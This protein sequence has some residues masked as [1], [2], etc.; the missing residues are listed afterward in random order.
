MRY[1]K[2]ADETCCGDAEASH[3]EGRSLFDSI[4]SES[5]DQGHGHGEDVDGDRHEL[6]VCGRVAKLL[7]HRWHSGRE[8]ENVSLRRT[9]GRASAH[10]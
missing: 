1:R 8:A 10:P 6:G 7:D 4:G 3:N 2:L 9:K 5:E